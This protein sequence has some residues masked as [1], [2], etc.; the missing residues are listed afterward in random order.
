MKFEIFENEIDLERELKEYWEECEV[1]N[2]D[3]H[4]NVG[5]LKLLRSEFA[6][7]HVL[8]K[9]SKLG[10]KL[11][12]V[13]NIR[14]IPGTRKSDVISPYGFGSLNL[15]G[16][17]NTFNKEIVEDHLANT[18]M[19]IYKKDYASEV[20]LLNPGINPSLN[21]NAYEGFSTVGTKPVVV[22][23]IDVSDAERVSR[24]SRGHKSSLNRARRLGVQVVS[25]DLKDKSELGVFKKL[26]SETMARSGASAR[27]RFT[28]DFF[29][30]AVERIGTANCKIFH[31]KVGEEVAASHFILLSGQTMYYFFG[32]S[33]RDFNEYRPSC[34]LI[35]QIATWGQRNGFNQYVLGGGVTE[36]PDDP[37]LQFKAGFTDNL[38]DMKILGRIGRLD[39]YNS[40]TNSFSSNNSAMILQEKFPNYRFG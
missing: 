18:L 12:Q 9:T 34:I 6:E 30:S 15:L 4:L 7:R 5:Y 28:D 17:E 26:H 33:N 25:A 1:E 24:Y 36:A 23:E 39:T 2:R 11:F 22:I 35:D 3:I 37:L 38:V 14:N 29:N 10:M 27:W 40:L 31:A 13:F 20:I 32:G 16:S 21:D 19:Y 8:L